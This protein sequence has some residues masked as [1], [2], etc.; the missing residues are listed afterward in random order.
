MRPLALAL[1]LVVAAACDG[2]GPEYSGPADYAYTLTVS[3]FCIPLGPL[4]VTVLDDAVVDVVA[5]DAPDGS[6]GHPEFE[7]AIRDAALTLA[8]LSE[9]AARAER[10]AAEVRVEYDPVRG[11]PTLLS[12]DWH[13]GIADDEVYYTATDYEAR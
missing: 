4:R 12:I 11:Y 7:D 2:A 13:A 3:C 5:L 10:E 8:E 6:E 1:L 9:L